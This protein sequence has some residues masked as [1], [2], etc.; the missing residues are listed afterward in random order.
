MSGWAWLQSGIVHSGRQ[1]LMG[2][3]GFLVTGLHV[4]SVSG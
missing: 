4:V 1:C 3:C 2:M